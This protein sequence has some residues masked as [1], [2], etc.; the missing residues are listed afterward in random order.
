MQL[1]RSLFAGISFALVMPMLLLSLPK[2]KTRLFLPNK[3]SEWHTFLR[4]LPK[5]E[6]PKKVFQFEG[7]VLH[8]SG[9][10]F[11]YITTE[12]NYG[13]FHFTIEFKWGQK[14]YPPRE[15]A[16]R[17]AGI[18]YHVILYSGDKIW[19]RSLEYQIQEGDCGDFW[20]T[21]STTIRHADSIT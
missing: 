11:G 8:V 6:D 19:P 15:N 12:K 9:E 16:K 1:H 21:D 5:N 13:D 20:M 14:K 18:M 17:D 4:G 7:D 3:K 10:T 2:K